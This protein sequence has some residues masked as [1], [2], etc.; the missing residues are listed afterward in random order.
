MRGAEVLLAFSAVMLP[1][2]FAFGREK[3]DV[4]TSS[5]AVYPSL[6]DVGRVRAGLDAALRRKFSNF[7]AV[8]P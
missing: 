6:T 3:A 8:N 1:C 7:V 2:K 5:L 4:V